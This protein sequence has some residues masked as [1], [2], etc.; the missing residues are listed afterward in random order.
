MKSKK[1]CDFILKNLCKYIDKDVE[2]DCC[3]KIKEHLKSCK[4]CSKEY[5]D[6]EKV[7]KMCKNSFETL[8]KEEKKRIFDNIK[9]LL[10]KE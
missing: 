10:E 5:K 8:E 2:K 7:I 3:E 1:D 9:Q 4:S 6:L